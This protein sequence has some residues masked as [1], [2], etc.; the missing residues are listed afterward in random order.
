MIVV[1]GATTSKSEGQLR[2]VTVS[3]QSRVSLIEAIVGWWNDED[4]VVPRELI[5]PPG[6]TQE[7]V[8]QQNAEDFARFPVRG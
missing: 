7:Q 3:V 1:T 8:E 6:Q 5:F 4:A 2:F